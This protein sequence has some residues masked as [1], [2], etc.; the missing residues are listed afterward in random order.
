[1]II[2]CNWYHE[3]IKTK[4]EGLYEIFSNTPSFEKR[5]LNI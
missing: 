5:K 2:K 3:A 4:Q 1:M